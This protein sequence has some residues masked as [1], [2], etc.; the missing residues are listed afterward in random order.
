MMRPG[1]KDVR[2]GRMSIG[3]DKGTRTRLVVFVRI[4]LS[5]LRIKFI[6]DFFAD[7]F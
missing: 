7:Q 2:V 4:T 5:T 6:I 1:T 3:K